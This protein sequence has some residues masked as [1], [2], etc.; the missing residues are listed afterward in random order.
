[1]IA[2]LTVGIGAALAGCEQAPN[3]TADPIAAT[4]T[5]PTDK[6]PPSTA[7]V[8]KGV[9]ATNLSDQQKAIQ[10]ENSDGGRASQ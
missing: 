2:A 10:A 5:A 8:A 6:T 7:P 3:P 9:D 4:K 1:M